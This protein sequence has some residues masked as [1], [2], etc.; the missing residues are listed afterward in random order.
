VSVTNRVDASAPRRRP[1]RCRGRR[2]C[3]AAPGGPGATPASGARASESPAA[4]PGSAA[5]RA[6]A[7]RPA[8]ARDRCRARPPAHAGWPRTRRA[9][10]PG[11]PRR[12]SAHR[13]S[14]LTRSRHGCCRRR[15]ASAA[16]TG[17]RSAAARC[18]AEPRPTHDRLDPSVLREAPTSTPG[19]A[20]RTGRPARPRQRASAPLRI[21]GRRRCP[22]A[23]ARLPATPADGTA[24][25]RTR[26]TSLSRRRYAPPTVLDPLVRGSPASSS[27]L[28]H[29]DP[30]GL[31]DA[32]ALAAVEGPQP[33]T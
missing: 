23:T 13:S 11:S 25:D 18:A 20:H 32:V 9:P 3:R 12:V 8:P 17:A 27:A 15:S 6:R 7:S 19:R 5:A 31:Q 26:H 33:S 21:P 4:V 30:I 24:A 16:D 29:V 14:S 2:R 10:P 28:R 22:V 1:P